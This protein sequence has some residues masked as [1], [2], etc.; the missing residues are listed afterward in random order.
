MVYELK[1]L[2]KSSSSL[3]FSRFNYSK[4]LGGLQCSF[5]SKSSLALM[6]A[7]WIYSSFLLLVSSPTR[8]LKV[9]RLRFCIRDLLRV[10]PSPIWCR[11]SVLCF[12]GLVHDWKGPFIMKNCTVDYCSI[13]TVWFL[14]SSPGSTSAYHRISSIS[15]MREGLLDHG[16]TLFLLIFVLLARHILYYKWKSSNSII[17]TSDVVVHYHHYKYLKVFLYLPG[18]F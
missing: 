3:S 13:R 17:L 6:V 2:L 8:I 1:C 5:R 16:I 4:L 7:I 14:C 11:P 15:C 9:S 18:S 12:I 10:C